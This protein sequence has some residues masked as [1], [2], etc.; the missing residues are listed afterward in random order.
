MDKYTFGNCMYC[1]EY[2]PLKNNICIDCKDKAEIPE[3]FQD[4]FF[5]KGVDND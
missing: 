4:L 5:K 2:K 3:F 1:K